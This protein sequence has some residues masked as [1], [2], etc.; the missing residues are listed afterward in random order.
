MR[1]LVL[2]GLL[3]VV[4]AADAGSKRVPWTTSRIVGAPE[5]PPPYRIERV[6]PKLTFREPLLLA[7]APG[8]K[9]WFLGE[10]AGKLYSFRKD[11]ACEKADL[12]LDLT[13][14]LKS[15]DRGSVRGI[16]AVYA[17]AFHPQFAKNRFCYVMYVLQ[18]KDGAKLP[19]GSRVA[20]FKV[21]D[22]DP[23]RIDPASETIIIT[24]PAGG[25]NGCDMHFGPDG[26]LYISTGDGTPP[27]P[28]DA[29]ETGQ[30]C[31]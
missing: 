2:M 1:Y 22:A 27:N 30:D 17:L 20:R 5:P 28:P 3:L 24:W 13:T 8:I 21:T 10:Q 14:E 23:P 25:H 16:D 4:S 6:F 7:R 29:L 19:E 18:P 26:F 31:S 11:Q 9:R 15:W 12:A